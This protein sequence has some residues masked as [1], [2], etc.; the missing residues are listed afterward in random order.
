MLSKIGI[1]IPAHN[2]ESR[3]ANCLSSLK[4]FQTNG[5]VI[6]VVDAQSTDQ[7]ALV[8]ASMGVRVIRSKLKERGYVIYEGLEFIKQLHPACEYIIIAHAD[9][10]FH[11]DSHHV[12]YHAITSKTDTVWGCFGHTIQA[13]GIAYRILEFGNAVRAGLFRFPYGDQAQFFRLDTLL[14]IGFPNQAR[15]EDLELCFLFQHETRYYYLNHPVQIPDR[16]WQKGILRTTWQNWKT[17][18]QYRK[19][20]NKPVFSYNVES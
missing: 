8:A 2:E 15:Y 9:M 19:N 6:I 17:V 7:T 11:A 4:S 1:I 18:Y 13:H 14:N 5:S 16:H 20:R 12:F 3:I 10:Q